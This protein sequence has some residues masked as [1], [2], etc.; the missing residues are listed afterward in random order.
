MVCGEIKSMAR[1]TDHLCSIHSW[2]KCGICEEPQPDVDG[3]EDHMRDHPNRTCSECH[4]QIPGENYPSHLRRDHG[5]KECPFCDDIYAVNSMRQHIIESHNQTERCPVCLSSH[6][7]DGLTNHLL[8]EHSWVRCCFCNEAMSP[9]TL[10]K[11]TQQC[12][13]HYDPRPCPGCQ[14]IYPASTLAVHQRE[15]HSHRQCPFCPYL[16]EEMAEHI[17]SVHQNLR[18]NKEPSANHQAP[19][20]TDLIQHGDRPDTQ[21]SS[22]IETIVENVEHIPSR[23]LSMFLSALSEAMRNRQDQPAT[24]TRQSQ[25]CVADH[26]HNG[27]ET[28]GRRS[29][30]SESDPPHSL[31]SVASNMRQESSRT[32]SGTTTDTTKRKAPLDMR[33]PQAVKRRKVAALCHEVQLLACDLLSDELL[34]GFESLLSALRKNGTEYSCF[35]VAATDRLA[36]A[37]QF[38]KISI[39]SEYR[40]DAFRLLKEL[41]LIL[42]VKELD[43]PKENGLRQRV[44]SEE[45]DKVLKYQQCEATPQ[46]RRRLKAQ[47]ERG[48]KLQKL[49]KYLSLAKREN[50]QDLN[51][52]HDALRAHEARWRIGQHVLDSIEQGTFPEGLQDVEGIDISRHPSDR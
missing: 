51:N 14:E 25:L 27:Q 13:D 49:E 45:M 26:G 1:L 16:A 23:D 35:Q 11:H 19:P 31:C 12:H 48:R 10:G 28:V 41:G 52:F 37:S 7:K 39:R 46:N 42:M 20:E 21:V 29:N 18:V 6:T 17:F 40:T 36:R 38:S 34:R 9:D 15:A 3:L 2:V 30:W 32:P 4:A 44:D 22:A 8:E 24:A 33:T 5:F 43:A 50:Q 47:V